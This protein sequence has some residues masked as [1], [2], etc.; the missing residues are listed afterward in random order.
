MKNDRMTIR[1]KTRQLM[2]QRRTRN[3][4]FHASA[5]TFRPWFHW[6][7]LLHQRK[8][9]IVLLETETVH[10]LCASRPW[11]SSVMMMM[12]MMT[13]RGDAW[14]I[15]IVVLCGWHQHW[16]SLLIHPPRLDSV[17]KTEE[18][19]L[20]VRKEPGHILQVWEGTT[21]VLHSVRLG[22]R[23]GGQDVRHTNL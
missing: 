23:M 22:Q 10:S 13:P 7:L 21:L 11:C 2:D 3:H 15:V 14:V 8:N 4:C 19:L 6:I 9:Q 1:S 20:S 16:G 18:I 12:M 5:L 17:D